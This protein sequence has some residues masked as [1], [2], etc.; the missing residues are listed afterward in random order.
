MIPGEIHVGASHVELNAGR[1]T[2]RLTVANQGDRAIQ[3]GSHFHFFEVN[4]ALAFDREAARGMRL[5]IPAGMAIRFEPGDAREVDLV[6]YAGERRIH[7]FRGLAEG[8]LD[9][10]T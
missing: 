7:G 9:V 6:A 10:T 1:A 4:E 3:V 2:V 8:P 5:N